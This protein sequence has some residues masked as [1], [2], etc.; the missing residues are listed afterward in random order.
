MQYHLQCVGKYQIESGPSPKTRRHKSTAVVFLYT[1]HLG[2]IALQTS[3]Q[4]SSVFKLACLAKMVYSTVCTA[5]TFLDPV[6]VELTR[7]LLY[8]S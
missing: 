2:Q 6:A 5:N 4:V 7:R 8:V 1:E 3:A